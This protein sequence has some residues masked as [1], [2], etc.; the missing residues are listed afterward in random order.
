MM[1]L[2]LGLGDTYRISVD[3]NGHFHSVPI[4]A[5]ACCNSARNAQSKCGI[6]SDDI[7]R[8]WSGIYIW[9]SLNSGSIRCSTTVSLL[10]LLTATITACHTNWLSLLYAYYYCNDWYYYL[11]ITCVSFTTTATVAMYYYTYYWWL[12]LLYYCAALL[13]HLPCTLMLVSGVSTVNKVPQEQLGVQLAVC[14]AV[15]VGFAS[16]LRPGCVRWITVLLGTTSPRGLFGVLCTSVVV[17]VCGCVHISFAV[18]YASC[19]SI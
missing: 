13:W 14:F 9:S 7:R 6:V 10:L 12:A 19:L 3:K 1:K 4:T 2:D 8:Y 16:R 11:I 18:L 5:R 15:V 17:T